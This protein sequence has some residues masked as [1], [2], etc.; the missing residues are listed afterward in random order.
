M[1]KEIEVL[2]II[3]GWFIW[4]ILQL[5]FL[6]YIWKAEIWKKQLMYILNSKYDIN[7]KIKFSFWL[8]L[9]KILPKII[10]IIWIIIFIFSSVWIIIYF[11][12]KVLLIS[13][14]WNIDLILNKVIRWV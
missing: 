14:I 7:S 11:Y 8:F 4:S 2:I 5:S 13:V 10:Y 3:I 1:R 12:D 9:W 6:I